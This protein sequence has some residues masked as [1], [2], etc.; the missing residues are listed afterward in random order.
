MNEI[1][2]LG[3]A[4]MVQYVVA[5]VN[6]RIEICSPLIC[7]TDDIARQ[8]ANKRILI[9]ITYSVL[10]STVIMF[11]GVARVLGARGEKSQG[12]HLKYYDL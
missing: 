11:S 2:R 4:Y 5:H 10:L 3:P 1:P 6:W 7:V 8:I 12:L 9:I